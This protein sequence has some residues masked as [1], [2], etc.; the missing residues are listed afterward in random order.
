MK[1][2]I[3]CAFDAIIC[4]TISFE[5]GSR[6]C[7]LVEVRKLKNNSKKAWIIFEEKCINFIGK[8]GK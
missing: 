2:H 5:N 4:D 8:T 1:Y 6:A 7:V 3:L